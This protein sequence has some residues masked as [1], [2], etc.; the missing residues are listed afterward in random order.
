MKFGL[1][2]ELEVPE[3]GYSERDIY[4]NALAQMELAERVGF[5]SAYAVEHH[6]NPGYSH[7]PC[8]EILFAAATQRTRTMRLGTA[9]ILLPFTHPVR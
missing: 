1:F 8:P 6:F 4:H 5:D 3:S 7:S 2:Y 9:V